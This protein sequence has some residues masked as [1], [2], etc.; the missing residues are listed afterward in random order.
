MTLRTFHV[1]GIASNIATENNI[2]SK[3]DGILEI[4][5]LRAVE[6][7]DPTGKTCQVVV[8]RL[9]EMRIV[10]QN[11]NIVLLSHNIPY[12]SKLYFNHGDKVSKGDVLL[13]WTRSMPLSYLKFPVRSSLRT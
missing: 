10:D 3:F 12:G 8:S 5:E 1:G 13:E 4:D 6:T 11:T 7:T 2:T 9:A